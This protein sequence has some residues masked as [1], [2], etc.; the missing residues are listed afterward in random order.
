MR[1]TE[2]TIASKMKIPSIEVIERV[3]S[4]FSNFF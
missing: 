3:M 4:D 2:Q 1:H